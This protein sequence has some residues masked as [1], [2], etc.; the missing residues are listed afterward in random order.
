MTS[1]SPGTTDPTK[2]VVVHT[3][4]MDT[5]PDPEPVRPTRKRRI[6]LDQ[7]DGI[8]S[9]I[10]S[11][12]KKAARECVTEIR[13]FQVTPSG[14][15]QKSLTSKKD[16]GTRVFFSEVGVQLNKASDQR[17]KFGKARKKKI[18]GKGGKGKPGKVNFTSVAKAIDDHITKDVDISRP[19]GQQ[20]GAA[21]VEPGRVLALNPVIK[22]GSQT[23]QLLGRISE[24]FMKAASDME[25]ETMLA[26]QRLFVSANNQENVDKISALH[27]KDMLTAAAKAIVADNAESSAL[28]RYSVGALAVALDSV[29]PGTALT[30]QQE[31]GADMLS[32]LSVGYHVDASAR[33]DLADALKVLQAQIRTRTKVYGP[34]TPDEAAEAFHDP[35]LVNHVIA[36]RP[37]DDDSHAEQ[38]L[39]LTLVK[40]GWDGPAII[41]GTK[42][43]C[44]CCWLTL[45]LVLQ[46]GHNL[47]FNN[48]AGL[49]WPKAARGVKLVAEELGVAD[50]SVL[51]QHFA[52]AN[53]LT[54]D[55]GEFI[56]HLTAL[57][58][59]GLV[60]TVPKKGGGLAAKGLT[61]DQTARSV[62]MVDN[63]AFSTDKLPDE[64]AEYPGSPLYTYG[65]PAREDDSDVE[66]DELAQ[67]E[68]EKQRKEWTERQEKAAK[69]KAAKEEADKEK[70]KGDA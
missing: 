64:F 33:K 60:V 9:R 2:P 44:S 21:I 61:Q 39:A 13:R 31:R 37:P 38:Y 59:V 52:E 16:E 65:S 53:N 36:V 25:Y 14:V 70:G 11:K 28:R 50:I 54:N 62:Y 35:A 45:A 41:G 30:E 7:L 1:P 32:E 56:Q 55:D 47:K 43:P 51:M 5:T 6:L 24:L 46:H 26:N 49:Y 48:F 15:Q 8:D 57:E 63:P 10:S 27:L 67:E 42:N 3:S 19:Y 18:K 34:C 12:S 20:K 17:S 66:R 29:D 58:K 40:A 23:E 68:F 69:E 4:S 22:I